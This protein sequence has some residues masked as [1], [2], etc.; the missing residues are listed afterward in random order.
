[1]NC[2][3]TQERTHG[4]NSKELNNSQHSSPFTNA[5]LALGKYQFSHKHNIII[6]NYTRVR[7]LN[8]GKC[9]NISL[10]IEML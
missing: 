10:F 8:S 5:A 2:S 3:M 7:Y 1:M 6:M 9:M 4:P